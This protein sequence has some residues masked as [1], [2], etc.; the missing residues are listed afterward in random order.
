MSGRLEGK[1]AFITGGASG[2]GAATAE[3]FREE[4]A[5]VVT[6]DLASGDVELDVRRRDSVEHA[7]AA[8]VERLGGLDIAVC[9]AGKGIFGTVEE[10]SEEDWDDGMAT[11]L[12]G[13]FLVAKASWPHLAAS[14]GVVLATGSVIGVWGDV[15]QGAY[16]ASKA[17][18]IAL[19]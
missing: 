3:R 10:L 13:V 1:R 4:G 8:A 2:I 6:G 9:N 18:V 15:N 12:K 19:T 16:C 11:N 14:G 7:V 5:A 17:G